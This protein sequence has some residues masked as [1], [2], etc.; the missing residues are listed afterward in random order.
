MIS[1]GDRIEY[2]GLGIR[3]ITRIEQGENPHA[4]GKKFGEDLPNNKVRWY[5]DNAYQCLD[6]LERIPKVWKLVES[7][8]PVK[9][10][11]GDLV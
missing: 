5:D 7:R 9:V 11:I 2:P 4:Y 10:R 8:I 3:T 1:V 6:S